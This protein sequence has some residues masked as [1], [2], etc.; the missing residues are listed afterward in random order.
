MY[1]ATVIIPAWNAAD[2]IERSLASVA[3]QTGVSLLAVVVDDASPDNT[4]AH[5]APRPW[6]KVDR[7]A[8]NGGP[9]A[10]R[11]RAIELAEGDW[12]VILDADDTMKPD[13]VARMI[14]IARREQAEI[15]LGNFQH[16]DSAGVSLKEKPF[17]DPETINQSEHISLTD[18]VARN[19]VKRGAASI[20]YLKPLISREFL[21]QSGV[22][23]NLE[24]RN[25][26]DCHLIFEALAEGARVVI[27]P[28]PNYLYTVRP[29]SVS[30]RANPDHIRALIEADKVFVEKYKCSM[31][32]EAVGLFQ[33]RDAALVDMMSAERVLNALRE[34]DVGQAASLLAERPKTL[35]RV[36]RQIIEGLSRRIL[37]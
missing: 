1:D 18:Y 19:Q 24:L 36:A 37:N 13:R 27:D 9:A 15:V 22:K 26:E 28:E 6:V 30:H 23:Y 14:D 21:Q 34:R 20:G 3:E 12:V 5:I 7:L 32:E 8:V 10:A 31:T 2:T 16:V 35:L 25:G 33:S 17:L 11:N 29:G 4:A